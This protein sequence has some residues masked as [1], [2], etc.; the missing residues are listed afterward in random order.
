MKVNKFS[1]VCDGKTAI[2]IK[3]QG[4]TGFLSSSGIKTL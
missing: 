4:A 3:E 1:A 2:F